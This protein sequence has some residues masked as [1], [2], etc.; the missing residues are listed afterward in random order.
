MT[1]NARGGFLLVV[2]TLALFLR[3]RLA[4]WVSLGIPLSF[5]GAVALMPAL[6]VS[7]NFVSLL[8]FIVVL[9]IVVDDAIVVGENTHTEQQRT[10]KK[11]EGAILGAQTIVVPVTFGVLTTITA[12]MPFLFLPGPMGRASR[13]VPLVVISCL[14]FSVFEA[15]FVLPAHLGHGHRSL[16]AEPSHAI[17]RGWQRVQERIARG[18]AFVI[19]DLYRP[20]LDRALEWRYMTV[21]VALALLMVTLGVLGG[22]WLPFVFETPVEMDFL[23]A[24]L[25]MAEGTPV[26]RTTE[27][28]RQMEVAAGAVRDEVDATSGGRPSVFTHVL[29]SI[30]EQPSARRRGRL[31]GV[32]R[33]TADANLGEVQLELVHFAERELSATELAHRWREAVGEIPGA[34][35]LKFES[36]MVNSGLPIVI[37][38]SGPELEPLRRAADEI[39]HRLAAYTGVFD[40]TD[41]FRGG[42]QELAYTIL[43][44]GEALGLTMADLARQLRQ[45]FYGEEAQIVQRGRD[46]V[47]V[48]VR[49]PA[50]Q[51]RS[52]EHVEQ[53]RVRTPQGAEVPFST[54]AHAHLATGFSGIR[55]VDRRRVVTVSADVD[56]ANANANEIVADLKHGVLDEI[57][58]PYRG[59]QYTFEGEQAEQRDFLSA[60]A[61]G[62]LVAMLVIY[63]L[64]AVP[65]RSYLHPLIIM[66]AIPFGVVGA[67]LGHVLLGYVFSMYS[68]LGLAALSG[69]VVNASLVLVDFINRRQAEGLPLRDAVR[70]AARGRFRPILLTSLTTYLGLTPL[71]LETSAQ[72]RF[73]IPMAISI[74]YGVM[75]ASFIT[76]FL[77]PASYLILDDLGRLAERL[78]LSTGRSPS[79]AADVGSR[80]AEGSS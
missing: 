59:V 47:K 9:G 38:L 20:A 66:I 13:V 26:H 74:A 32:G 10:G 75:F 24:R 80:P 68:V 54:V 71:M 18:L 56:R 29:A 76:L 12:F 43:P 64:L 65:L 51:R 69:V 16:D 63:T 30:G 70:T 41:S 28:I 34:A 52:L 33:S 3:L 45:G 21:A 46:E 37:E 53:V 36:S 40:I 8:G 17:S 57:I 27:A 6:D 11:L 14:L 79:S 19:D 61:K 1:R 42:K 7:I 5:L 67:A 31:P 48:M 44:A 72:A 60:L 49:Y 25:T 55:H 73:M 35:E 39:K 62:Y 58:N 15:M 78:H 2:L 22:G 23:T 77:V 50:A 4:F